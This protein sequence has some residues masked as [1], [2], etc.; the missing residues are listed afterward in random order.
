LRGAVDDWSPRAGDL[1][2]QLEVE[3][4]MKRDVSDGGAVVDMPVNILDCDPQLGLYA[5]RFIHLF[6]DWYYFWGT[7]EILWKLFQTSFLV[8]VRIV[9]KRFDLLYMLLVSYM[10][11]TLQGHYSPY[12]DDLDDR[13]S[14]KFLVIEFF[15]LLSIVGITYMNGWD[16]RQNSTVLLGIEVL[17]LKNNSSQQTLSASCTLSVNI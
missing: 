1:W 13:L 14:I 3:P 7:V 6:E 2:V 9:D 16:D 5:K 15:L 17:P 10:I 4:L 12:V 8:L 11:I